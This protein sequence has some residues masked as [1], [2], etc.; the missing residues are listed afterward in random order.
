MDVDKKN[1]RKV[2]S[3]FLGIGTLVALNVATVINIYGFPSEAFYGLTSIT[4]YV[5]ALVVFLV[6]IALVSAELG[7]MHPQ[8]GGIF[9]W[10]SSAFSHKTGLFAT[11]LQWIQS[12]F[13]YPLSL[14]FAAV[15][16]SYII[17]NQEIANAVAVNKYYVMAFILVMF[18]LCTFL[19]TKE[20]KHIGTVS[21]YGVWLGIIIPMILLVLLAAYF[22]L[23]GGKVEMDTNPATLIP[24]FDSVN[25]FVM[26]ISIMLFF[27]GLEV[28]GVHVHMMKNPSKDYPKALFWSSLII[29][30]IYILGT[31]SIAVIIPSKELNITQ[32]VI[33]ALKS[34]FTFAGF[35]IVIPFIALAL[36]FGV[37]ANTLTWI[38]GPTSAIKYIA[39][40]GFLPKVVQRQ[41]KNGA[42]VVILAAQA[43]IVTVL[44]FVYIISSHV[45]QGYQMLL[46]ITN[47]LYLTMYLILFASFIRL[48]YKN[49][50]VERPFKVGRTMF[51]AWF[52]AIIGSLAVS[53]SF[54]LCF[55]PP[56]QLDI[57][58]QR[59]YVITLLGIYVLLI[60]PPLLYWRFK[61][62]PAKNTIK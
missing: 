53:V 33:T 5:I 2:S 19:A 4:F 30:V 25:Q 23:K 13:F 41:N 28:N 36:V 43:I 26:A 45:Q 61:V 44:C 7:S 8:Q 52:V 21:S 56:S 16:F 27:S 62:K 57:D 11:W 49:K 14:T 10:V 17:P 42:P 6:P 32:S 55:F 9:T 12:V 22:I 38:C 54:V 24:H 46:Q 51:T 40:Q 37:V 31:L 3:S 1:N 47:A 50:N 60:L 35:K 39:Q 15:T 18:L 58:H 34:Y 20:L 29:G 48:R 59:G